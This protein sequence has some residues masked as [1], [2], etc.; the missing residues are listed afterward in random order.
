MFSSVKENF[1]Y[2]ILLQHKRKIV[3]LLCGS[4]IVAF[5]NVLYPYLLKILI[6][7]LSGEE[8]PMILNYFQDNTFLFLIFFVFLIAFVDILDQIAPTLLNLI[9]YKFDFSIAGTSETLLFDKLKKLD[10]GF[11][12]NPKNQNLIRSFFNLPQLINDVLGFATGNLQK[13]ITLGMLFPIIAFLDIRIILI[14]LL[15]VFIQTILLFYRIPIANKNR[16]Q[17]EYIQTKISSIRW[18]LFGRFDQILALNGTSKFLKKYYDLREKLFRTSYPIEK[19]TERWRLSDWL[20]DTIPAWFTMTF[21]GFKIL[22][23]DLTIGDFTLIL[24]YTRQIQNIFSTVPSTLNLWSQFF[25]D[26]TRIN[27]FFHLK[28]KYRMIEPIYRGALKGD[29]SFH[30]VSFA[31][32]IFDETEAYMLKEVITQNKKQLAKKERWKYEDDEIKEWEEI[33]S[34]NQK[35][36]RLVLKNINMVWK[37]G[38][39]TALVGR[40]GAGKTTTTKL[41]LKNYTPTKGEVSVGNINLDYVDPSDVRNAVSIVTQ[42]PIF[43]D[44]LTLEENLLL[45]VDKKPNTSTIMKTLKRL[46][47]GELVAK[48]HKGLDV[49]VGEDFRCSA[50]QTQLF[51]IA[52]VL[53]QDRPIIIFDEGTNQLDP[54]HEATVMDILQEQKKKGKVVFIISHK[55]TTAAKADHIYVMDNCKILEEGNHQELL[56]KKGLYKKFWHLQVEKNIFE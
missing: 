52:R 38:E 14:L 5:F 40:N 36:P 35:K 1:I 31:Y 21:I 32:P 19:Q 54:E 7:T 42:D 43:F 37:S 49:I 12:E 51:T 13:I 20:L 6:D 8:R 25:L 46:G 22:Q 24:A 16:T 50:G 15:F 45:G 55:I 11:L 3:F 34:T 41:S 17:T 39:I 4:S 29:V 30:Q 9:R 48:H 28:P 10:T 2:K 56:A 26:Y 27:F 18:A 47:V 53:F 33:F 44:S 23:G